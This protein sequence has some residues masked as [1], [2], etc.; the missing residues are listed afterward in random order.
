MNIS[1]IPGSEAGPK[2]LAEGLRVMKHY[3]D[4]A[5]TRSEKNIVNFSAEAKSSKEVSDGVTKVYPNTV[6]KTIAT[7][8]IKES[9]EEAVEQVAKQSF[10]QFA[11]NVILNQTDEIVGA[12]LS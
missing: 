12:A 6:T 7:K 3:V 10:K 9:T 5:V 1:N 2:R 4:A 11:K 8:I